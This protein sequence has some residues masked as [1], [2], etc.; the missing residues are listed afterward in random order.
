P[1]AAP[2]RGVHSLSDILNPT[3]PGG[4]IFAE[5]DGSKFNGQTNA[6]VILNSLIY[7][8]GL[9]DSNQGIVLAPGSVTDLSGTSVRNP[10]A[11][12]GTNSIATGRMVD[13]GSISTSPTAALNGQNL[14]QSPVGQVGSTYQGLQGI[15]SG[16][17]LVQV[18]RDFVLSAGSTLNL[19]GA[20]D[21]Y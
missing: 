4:A 5:G 12:A 18:G 2:V 16:L 7:F 1:G 8:T 17:D 3:T 20:S 11:T 15:G 10:Y 21:T 13:G 19:S 14:Y 6:Q 9:L